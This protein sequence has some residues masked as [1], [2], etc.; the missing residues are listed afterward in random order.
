MTE[1]LQNFLTNVYINVV[2]NTIGKKPLSVLDKDNVTFSTLINTILE[3]Y[4]YP[5]VLNIRKHSEQAKCISFSE[6]ATTEVLK[7]MRHI[8]IVKTRGEDQ[9][10]SNVIKT[11]ANFLLEP[12]TD[13]SSCFNT[14]TFPDL[15]RRSSVT[16][17]DNGGTDKDTC[18]NYRPVS[19]LNTFSKIMKS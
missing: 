8:N 1:K 19:V 13:I 2:E 15:A 10:P 5:S 12:L 6:M 14:N 18:T 7:L 16:P 11:A 17:I 9:L 3:E 4:K